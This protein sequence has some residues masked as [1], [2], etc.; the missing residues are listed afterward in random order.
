MDEEKIEIMFIDFVI[1]KKFE[2][3]VQY[4]CFC[5]VF[6]LDIFGDVGGCEYVYV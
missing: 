5:M 3:W 4:Q 2:Q 1:I 6:I